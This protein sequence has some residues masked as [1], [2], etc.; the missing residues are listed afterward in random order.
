LAYDIKTLA[1]QELQLVRDE[2]NLEISRLLRIIAGLS[3]GIGLSFLALLFILVMLVQGLH[4]GTGWPLWTCYGVVAVFLLGGGIVLIMKARRMANSLH[5]T[6]TRS[7]R[8]FKENVQWI[9]EHMLSSR[10]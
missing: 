1:H 4:E 5:A 6:P 3:I 7:F 10:T 9:R 2:V 8:V